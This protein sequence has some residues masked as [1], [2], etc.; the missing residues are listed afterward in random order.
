MIKV[1]LYPSQVQ[2]YSATM[3]I[4]LSFR[5]RPL[6]SYPCQSRMGLIPTNFTVRSELFFVNKT[7]AIP[8]L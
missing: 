7:F 6:A 2:S 4:S 1:S 3:E 5:V 8:L